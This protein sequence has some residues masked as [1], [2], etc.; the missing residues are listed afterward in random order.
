MSAWQLQQVVAE[1]FPRSYP[2]GGL[3]ELNVQAPQLR[4]LPDLNRLGA[5]IRLVAAG[6]ALQ[7]SYGG[8]FDLDFALRFEISDLSIRVY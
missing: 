1:R 4:L 2:L 7:C 6:L 5:D 3:L 8:R